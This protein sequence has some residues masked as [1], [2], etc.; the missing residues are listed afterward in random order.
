MK[1]KEEGF[2]FFLMEKEEQ[3]PVG[4]GRRAWAALGSLGQPEDVKM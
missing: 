2:F 3:A 1:E 4:H